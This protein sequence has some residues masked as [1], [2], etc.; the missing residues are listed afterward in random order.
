M[1][2]KAVGRLKT[3]AVAVG[4]LFSGFFAA[5]GALADTLGMPTNGGIGLQPAGDELRRQAAQFH[6]WILMPIIVAIS[7]FVLGLLIWIVIRFN[8]KANPV[9][10]KFTHNTRLEIVW[11]LVPVIIL[12]FIAAFSF[13]LLF[14][15]HDVPKA[16]VTLKATGNQWYWAYEYPD[17][18]IAEYVSN[19]LSEQQAAAAGAPYKLAVNNPI[20]VPVGKTIKVL[21][22]GADVLHAFFVPAF[23]VQ[24]TAVPGRVNEVWFQT[25]KV[26]KYYGQCNELCGVDH[27][28]MPIEVD[29]VDQPTW[30]RLGG[31]EGYT[32]AGRH[33]GHRSSHHRRRRACDRSARRPRNKDAAGENRRARLSFEQRRKI[34]PTHPLTPPIMVTPTTSI[35]SASPTSGC[36]PPTTRTSAPSTSSSPSWRG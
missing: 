29:V 27:S 16:D 17:Q 31:K 25:E 10:Q 22:T 23:G 33:P 2:S 34:W 19:P 18:K 20:V 21:V 1:A 24:V 36:S 9:P 15:Y 12:V 32:R 3:Q 5:G 8:S 4:A 30:N 35:R 11:T 14:K 13:P 28:F 26:G 6:D 7:L